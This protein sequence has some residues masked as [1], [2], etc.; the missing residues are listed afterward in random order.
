MKQ[1]HKNISK[2]RNNHY[3]PEWYQKGFLFNPTEKLFYLDLTPDKIT[4]PNGN[5]IKLP[6]GT[7]KTHN[8]ISYLN[9]SQCFFQTDLY[10]TF[11]GPYINDEIEKKLFGEIDN[12]G[13][14]AVR[15][16][17]SEDVSG[18]HNHFTNFFSYIDAQKIRTPKGLDW[19]KS[20]YPHLEQNK[21][22]QEMQGIR[23]MHCT[24]WSEG[25]REIASAKNSDV[26]F[27]LS[28]HPITIYN[29]ACPPDGEKCIYPNDPAIILKG[30]QTIFPLDK[31]HC[32]ILTNCE[33]AKN[34]ETEKPTDKRTFA[35]HNRNSMVRTDAFIRTRF[36]ND[37]D[38]KK[39][40]LII[41]ARA[42]RYVAAS[43]KE[44]L[45]P[46]REVSF[47]WAE[48]RHCLLP[49]SDQLW[50]YGGKMYVGYEDGSTYY[51]DAFGR[52][53]LENEFLKKPKRERPPK[54]NEYCP[55]GYGRKFKKCCSGKS[56][57]ERPSWEE[58][59]IRER[60]ITFFNGIS[61]ILGMNKGKT[62]DDIR[63]ELSDEQV[64]KIYK[65]YGFLWPLETDIISLLPKPDKS[66][67][68]LYTGIIDPRVISEF[69]I[70]LTSY[71]DEII[72]QNPIMNP[73]CVAPKFNPIEHPHSHK[74]QALKDIMLMPFIEKGYINLIPDPCAFDSHLRSQMFRMAEERGRNPEVH[75]K[76]MELMKWLHKDDFERSICM[77]PQSYKQKQI[78][79]ALP[80]L[81]DNQV[82]ETIKYI[83]E[84]NKTDPFTV[85]Q[86]DIL[87]K[88]GGQLLMTNLSPNFEIALF[89]CQ[90]TGSFLLTDNHY[91]W[92]E[93]VQ[94]QHREKGIVTYNWNDLVSMIN[95]FEYKLKGSP[96]AAFKLR[97]SG[98]L[99]TIRRAIKEVYSAIQ[100][101]DDPK[102]INLSIENLKNQYEAAYKAS[103]KELDETDSNI[104]K[105]RFQCLIPQGGIVHNNV[106]RM[107]LTCGN[108]NHMRNVPMAI[109]VEHA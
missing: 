61:D 57:A 2:T 84:K 59:S 80:K 89:L 87:T 96:E 6:D 14:K 85:L 71:F 40:N 63:K 92:D 67:R 108:D 43:K 72:I 64:K 37:E 66:A 17:I 16:F 79:E 48:L 41:K 83:E 77:M 105:G 33:Y 62:W 69:A 46:E 27:I 23:N 100:D 75:E 53:R 11:F 82:E 18:W 3:V 35:R 90:A 21:L 42:K 52:T 70:S 8:S 10:T 19:I 91:R 88:E 86:A 31:D 26:K 44:W 32:L 25:V 24:I 101:S 15:A 65:L 104:F 54:P 58:L 55:C 36:L 38:V 99:G 107:L 9:T 106:Q 78:R 74:Q 95:S 93:I 94:A 34:P 12:A 47:N 76:D 51:Q 68:A 73:N 22:M 39:I 97:K 45:Y 13:S 1:I 103:E 49:P 81:N 50:H 29:Y 98:K 20:H 5:L 7:P 56:E 102:K 4:R 60:N 109:L 28:D 30:S